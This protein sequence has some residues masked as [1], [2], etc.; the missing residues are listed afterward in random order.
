MQSPSK[1]QNGSV[2]VKNNPM[3]KKP[4]PGKTK[5][6]KKSG[7]ESSGTFVKSASGKQ[8]FNEVTFDEKQHLIAEAAYY[9]AMRRSFMP[10]NEL[11]DWLDAEVEIEKML[12]EINGAPRGA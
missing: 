10:G 2:H 3:F 7:I 12:T 5:V 9:R 4:T 1:S 8:A 11:E 6:A